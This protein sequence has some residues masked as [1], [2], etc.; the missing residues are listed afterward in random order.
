MSGETTGA[1]YKL[2]EGVA[3]TCGRPLDDPAITSD[4]AYSLLGYFW[5]LFGI[6]ATPRYVV[7]KCF[8]CNRT[9]YK[10][11]DPAIVKAHTK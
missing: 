1:Q 9:V 8:A 7:F 5:L 11:T 2:P 4:P 6:T 3:C 10:S